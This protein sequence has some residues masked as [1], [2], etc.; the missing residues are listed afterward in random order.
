MGEMITGF[1]IGSVCALCIG[2][3]TGTL[4][5]DNA[6]NAAI[7]ECLKSLPRDQVCEYV[8]IATPKGADNE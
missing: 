2:A 5:S 8:V 4:A 1:F 6:V 7:D 3:C